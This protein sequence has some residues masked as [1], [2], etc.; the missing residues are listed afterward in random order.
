[1]DLYKFLAIR[2]KMF[3]RVYEIVRQI[4]KGKV[5]TYGII[6]KKLN[7]DFGIMNSGKRIDART[8][9]WALH[10]NADPNTPCHR[11]VNK[12]G[13]I[14]KSYA[15]GGAEKQKEKLLVEGVVFIDSTHVN[16]DQCL[17]S[18]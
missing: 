5:T 1:M 8:V 15:F 2:V 16:L 14:A 6:A 11:V 4:P 18:Y 13:E 10:A 7:H 17:F 9:G 12:D 3:T